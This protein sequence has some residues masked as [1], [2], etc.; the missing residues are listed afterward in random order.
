MATAVHAD[1]SFAERV[2][3]YSTTP[4]AW[5]QVFIQ[6]RDRFMA[7]SLT[8]RTRALCGGGGC[9]GDGDDGDGHV[10]ATDEA[11]ADNAAGDEAA[12]DEASV[13]KTT[14]AKRT[15]RT[16][17]T[18]LCIVG[19]RHVA[20]LIESLDGIARGA[21]VVTVGDRLLE[22]PEGMQRPEYNQA[23]MMEDS[24]NAYLRRFLLMGLIGGGVAAMAVLDPNLAS[25]WHLR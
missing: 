1:A 5:D 24:Q 14:V 19:R 20:G 9:D 25:L 18:I 8:Y 13:G 17:R 2:A 6:E 23:K 4:D 15:K 3:P 21:D 11:A 7:A 10:V 12:G 22:T 16:K